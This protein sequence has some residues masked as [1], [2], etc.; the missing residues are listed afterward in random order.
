MCTHTQRIY[1]HLTYTHTYTIHPKATR[2]TTTGWVW[3]HTPV[4]LVFGKRG[5]GLGFKVILGYI[6]NLKEA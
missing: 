1:A 5:K 2:K 6:V 3:W 4:I